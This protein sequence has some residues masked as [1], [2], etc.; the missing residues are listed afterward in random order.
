M[1][2]RDSIEKI[3]EEK[4]YKKEKKNKKLNLSLDIIGLYCI[5]MLIFLF[6]LFMFLVSINNYSYNTEFIG[7]DEYCEN[8]GI[9][10]INEE[11]GLNKSIKLTTKLF[12][13]YISILFIILYMLIYQNYSFKLKRLDKK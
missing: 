7:L 13:C 10:C 4:R 11:E 1:A 9:E 2:E 12:L 3:E 8:I 6:T 5:L